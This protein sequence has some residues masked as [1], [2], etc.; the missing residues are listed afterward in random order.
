MQTA[1]ELAVVRVA[2]G[3]GGAVGQAN[4]RVRATVPTGNFKNKLAV[5]ACDNLWC[6]EVVAVAVSEAAIRGGAPGEELALR[7]DNRTVRRPA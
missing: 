1:A 5:Q 4:K 3:H 7:R 6:I 2:E